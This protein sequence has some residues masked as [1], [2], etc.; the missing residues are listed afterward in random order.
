MA[1][2]LQMEITSFNYAFVFVFRS[3]IMPLSIA[4]SGIYPHIGRKSIAAP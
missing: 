2:G 4:I 3:N 1:K